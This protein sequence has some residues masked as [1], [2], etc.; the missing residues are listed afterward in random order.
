MKREETKT[1]KLFKV[2]DVSDRDRPKYIWVKITKIYM[3]GC[4]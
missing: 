2:D 4:T 1:M 3:I